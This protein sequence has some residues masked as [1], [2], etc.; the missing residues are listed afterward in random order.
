MGTDSVMFSVDH[1]FEDMREAAAFIDGAAIDG[2]TRAAI[3]HGNA[4]R[5]LRLSC[6]SAS[7]PIPAAVKVDFCT[8]V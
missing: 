7:A 6:S 4:T 5:I 1:P 2:A 3:C 8:E